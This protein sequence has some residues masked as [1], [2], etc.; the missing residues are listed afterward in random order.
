ML[1]RVFFTGANLNLNGA[2]TS[3]VGDCESRVPCISAIRQASGN[4]F[5]VGLFF[6]AKTCDFIRSES[7]RLPRYFFFSSQREKGTKGFVGYCLSR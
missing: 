4:C 1:G 6:S 7:G 5:E 2:F 3:D